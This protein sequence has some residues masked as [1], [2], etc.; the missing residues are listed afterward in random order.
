MLEQPQYPI[1]I[2]GD[3]KPSTLIAAYRQGIFPWYSADQPILWWSPDPRMVLYSAEF[4]LH[5]SLRK[6]ISHFLATP[7]AE[8]RIDHDFAH[9]IHA[10]AQSPRDGQDGT[11]IVP[12]MIDAYCQLHSA[13]H[14]H[15]VETW[16]HGRPIGGLYCVAIGAALFGESMYSTQSNASKIALAALVALARRE[17]APLIDCQQQT[18]HLSLH[19]ARPIQQ[20]HF[21]DTIAIQTERPALHW[22]FTPA[23][24]QHLHP[25]LSST[26]PPTQ[27]PLSPNTN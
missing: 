7:G 10:C 6:H 2:G 22:Q 25:T 17:N 4:R 20:Q 21:L 3:L 18:A 16:L 5:R 9:T 1:A 23:D 27:P 14:A 13:G 12:D 8:V 11:W 26:L 15:S 19:G 24:W